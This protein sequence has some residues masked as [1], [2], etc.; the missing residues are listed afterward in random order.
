MFYWWIAF[1]N[2]LHVYSFHP[3]IFP[4]GT[5]NRFHVI[6]FGHILSNQSSCPIV[7]VTDFT[8]EGWHI[9]PTTWRANCGTTWDDILYVKIS[10]S[11]NIRILAWWMLHLIEDDWSLFLV[12]VVP[13]VR[14]K[15]PVGDPKHRVIAC[16]LNDR[17]VRIGE[18]ANHSLP[19]ELCE[20]DQFRAPFN[21][22]PF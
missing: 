14:R 20:H 4:I 19:T 3:P 16:V 15:M 13:P 2:I 7:F 11:I 5:D 22:R 9:I 8:R 6:L 21:H 1:L 18:K 12:Q 10:Y 17:T